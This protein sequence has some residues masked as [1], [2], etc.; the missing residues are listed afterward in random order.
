MDQSTKRQGAA[1]SASF[2][3]SDGG[4]SLFAGGGAMSAAMATVDWA[5]TPLGPVEDWP[6][7]LRTA[8]SICLASRFPIL[9][10]WGPE[11]AMLYND[12]YAQ[13]LN[14]KHPAALGTPGKRVWPE[15]WDIIGPML[16]GV[17]Q[18]GKS[19]WSNDQLLLLERSG[20]SEECY[21]TF[22]YS[23]I[24]DES[25]GI[26]GVFSAVNE[27]TARVLAERRT[28]V[29]RDLA[30]A[31]VDAH[32]AEEVCARAA[33]VL[34][35]DNVDVPFA[36]FYL[37]DRDH[38]H[39]HL[40]A[41]AGVPDG[42]PLA[43]AKVALD[44]D[45]DTQGTS[46]LAEGV[47][48]WPFAAVARSGAPAIV[49][50]FSHWPDGAS[51]LSERSL[52]PRAVVAPIT[53]PGQSF[54][55]AILVAGVNS[56]RALDEEYRQFYD[57]LAM[58]LASALASA[59]AY[60][61][62]RRRAE[63]LAALDRAKT[64]FFSNV[65]HEFRTPLTLM[66]GPLEDLLSHRDA[67][68][69]E[70]IETLDLIHRNGLRLLKL[71]NS[72]LDFARIEAGRLQ[73][74]YEPIDLAAYTTDLASS[75]RSLIEKAGMRLSVDCLPLEASL[76]EPV[77]VDRAMWEKIVLNLLSN[78]FKHTFEGTIAVTLHAVEEGRAVELTV[79]DTGVGVPAV[80]LPRLFER[81]HRVEGARARTV[82]GSGIGLA[83]V[84]ELVRLHGG[85]IYAESAE[86]IGTTFVVRMPT[87][88]AHL[89]TEHV[90]A[91]ATPT[92][93]ALSVAS[94]VEEAERW[95]PANDFAAPPTTIGHA[96][97]RSQMVS[98]HPAR[99]LIADDNTD[100]REYLARLLGER[101]A[102]EAVANGAQALEAVRRNLDSDASNLPDL[103]VSDVMMPQLDGFGLLRALR[104]DPRTAA[105]PVIL[106]SARAGEEATIEG[107]QAGA[108][109]YLVKPFS[110]REVLTR[111]EARLEIARTRA[112]A[113]RHV[114]EALNAL[115]GL[116]EDTV[117]VPQ[118]VAATDDS[119]PLMMIG[120]RLVALIRQVFVSDVVA[121]VTL[122]P[123]TS[124]LRP[125]AVTGLEPEEATRWWSEA[126]CASLE[127]FLA[128]E[129]AARLMN[130]ELVEQDLDAEPLRTQD[131]HGMR[132]LVAAPLLLGDRVVGT[133]AVEHR[134]LLRSYT[135]D[136]RSLLMAMGRLSALAIER[137]RLLSEQMAAQAR[138]LA[139]VE[140]TRRMDEFLGIAS[141]ELRTPLTSMS[142]NVQMAE[143]QIRAIFEAES[144]ASDDGAAGKSST[145]GRPAALL[146]RANRQ[147]Q[148]LDRLV[149]DL[150][151]TSRIQAGKLELR[152]E[153]C[154][155][156][157]IARE[158]AQELQ[159]AWPGRDIALALRSREALEIMADADRIG[160][161]LTNLLTNALKYS[162]ETQPVEAR[163]RRVGEL[164]RVEVRDRGPGLSP[165]QQAR[166][167]ER[168]YRVPGIER[169]SGSGGGLG[170]GL[171]I[172]KTILE[173][174]GGEIGVESEP[175]AGSVFWFTLPLAP[176][177][178]PARG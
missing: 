52:S 151:D 141:H 109:D 65:S 4:L 111:V 7:S 120:D 140:T 130:G 24:Q 107:L 175:G 165:G 94:Y 5:R 132:Y 63:A 174:H 47:A 105:V 96:A 6:Q 168:F 34:A 66:L 16:E 58:H 71:V 123:V 125:V 147:A 148:R 172:C 13:I 21:F 86:G 143:R 171:Y 40:V 136:D 95:L 73:A 80:E 19:T 27:T 106:L 59:D 56:H 50:G 15:I 118:A 133:V 8:V 88:T 102:V 11:L 101:Y 89:P 53:E 48:Q 113:E 115:V 72:L 26:G 169:M 110:S 14:V 139:L 98:G 77:Y 155:L 31:I 25:G 38:Q 142:A 45:H 122:D 157:E 64:T 178:T 43:P 84:Q 18:E 129:V 3:Q 134:Q 79:R 39:A 17:L 46:G 167:F 81:F 51:A 70:E 99:L 41:S 78:A 104:A 154:D 68:P 23:P 162:A 144:S 160:Q 112:E 49:T 28:R 153:R 128:P 146:E 1:T 100:M 116:T 36:L 124:Q 82:E 149:T 173:R 22:S 92:T 61:E 37:L 69:A 156:V 119:R 161:V 103:V 32:T 108:D 91:P 138:E 42:S 126:S 163:V 145:L 85:S 57:L 90:R 60:A 30:V 170:L 127:D 10:W 33:S 114:R 9:I 35:R 117:R 74:S 176:R 166:L 93:P 62:E 67:L 29:A 135:V 121:M 83:L 97:T 12:A 20:Y 87:G 75:F 137:E 152:L 150:L 76:A 131:N 164:V 177:A 55:S 2:A 54:P 44:A 158:T 159:M